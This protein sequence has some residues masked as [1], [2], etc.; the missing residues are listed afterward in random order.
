MNR[1]PGMPGL[2]GREALGHHRKHVTVFTNGCHW[3]EPNSARI[4]PKS[5]RQS[6]VSGKDL[7]DSAQ[8]SSSFRS[9]LR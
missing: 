9:D 5:A 8:I 2:T 4:F 7:R 1:G 6:L 3:Q